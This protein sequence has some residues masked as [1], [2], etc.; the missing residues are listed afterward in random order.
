MFGN[1]F[2]KKKDRENYLLGWRKKS[3]SEP[4]LLSLSP[5]N[6]FSEERCNKTYGI[7]GT[8]YSAENRKQFLPNL[9]NPTVTCAGSTVSKF[10]ICIG[11][12]N[13]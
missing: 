12:Y 8:S 2:S 9:F 5:L 7:Y 13:V 3:E 1:L 10:D 6:L 11:I 4:S